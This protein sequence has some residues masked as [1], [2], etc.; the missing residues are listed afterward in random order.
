MPTQ[1]F[2]NKQPI[3]N[4]N[5][6]LFAYHLSLE[7]SDDANLSEQALEPVMEEF[8][9]RVAEHDGMAALTGDKPEFYSAPID[10]MQE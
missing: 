9:A 8:C 5:Q 1:L 4:A 3:L 7:V 10:V 6:E 2:I